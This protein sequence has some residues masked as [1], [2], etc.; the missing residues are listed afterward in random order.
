MKTK[1]KKE[2]IVNENSVADEQSTPKHY[3]ASIKDNVL[4]KIQGDFT[5]I[6]AQ[7]LT[8]QYKLDKA[9]LKIRNLEM[10]SLKEFDLL[11]FI[12]F[13]EKFKH[14]F[15]TPLDAEEK[16]RP[17]FPE[18]ER[19]LNTYSRRHYSK[20]SVLVMVS[21]LIFTQVQ[22][23]I[24]RYVMD[25]AYDGYWA[26]VH[27]VTGG[28][29][30]QV[31][32]YVKSRTPVGIVLVG[33]LPVPWFEMANDFHGASS[34]FPCDLY[35]MDLNGTWSDPDGDGK[36]QSH[37]GDLDPEIWVGRIWSPTGDGNDVGL[38]NNYFERNHMFRIGQL[39]H[40]RRAL[41]YVDDDW[42]GFNDCGM[43]LMTPSSSVTTY[44]APNQTDVDLYKSEVNTARAWVQVCVHSWPQGHSFSVDTGGEWVD[45]AYFRDVNPPNANF[46]NLFACGPGR[47][48]DDNYLG[49]WYIFDKTGNGTN[50]GL[51]AVA[52]AK[53][54][55]MLLF[56]DFYRPMGEGKTIGQ[57]FVEWW[58][59]R[60]PVHDEGE[61]QWYYGLTLLGDPTLNWWKGAVPTLLTPENGDVFNHW[62]RRLELKWDP[63][64]IPS[65]IYEVE[66]DYFDGSWAAESGRPSTHYH[67]V[68]GT[69]VIHNFVGMQPGRWRVRAKVDSQYCSWS[70]WSYFRFDI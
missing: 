40:S 13:K 66:V 64:N 57:A 15:F 11:S 46:Y 16:P 35:Y 70:P 18:N 67:N 58:K 50:H 32:S 34:E 21:S 47:F 38:I 69:S 8:R 20:G 25:L 37:N 43:S 39:G 53:T 12:R 17:V 42:Q 1:E 51:T 5:Y 14:V 61:Q 41:S 29:P 68:A 6:N 45:S 26:T 27:V 59:A 52:S 54:G 23:S 28:T 2:R 30:K 44:T 4:T 63:V 24:D 33:S 22:A 36:F 60:G 10:R 19:Y 31:R 7:N 56:E 9:Y 62:P 3:V 65:S 48:T 55:S 49:G